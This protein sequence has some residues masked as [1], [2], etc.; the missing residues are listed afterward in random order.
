MPRAHDRAFLAFILAPRNLPV[1][2]IDVLCQFQKVVAHGP[3]KSDAFHLRDSIGMLSFSAAAPETR[4]RIEEGSVG[5]WHEADRIVSDDVPIDGQ[6]VG[7]LLGPFDRRDTISDVQ[8]RR[9][10]RDGD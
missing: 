7:S 5:L 3:P 10:L 6:I 9:N 1:H 4:D 2:E 8:A